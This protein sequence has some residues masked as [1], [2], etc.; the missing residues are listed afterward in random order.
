[1]WNTG[2]SSEYV[3]LFCMLCLLAYSFTSPQLSL[4]LPP[5]PQAWFY[6]VWLGLVPTVLSLV[7]M[8]VSVRELG[9]T[10]TAIIGALEPLTAVAIGVL[11]FSESLTLR[12]VLGI[13]IILFAVILVV[14]GKN[15]PFHIFHTT[16]TH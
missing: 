4:Q 5:S 14:V 9:A 6:A 15:H 10:P 7:L 12:L 3:L 2:S 8:T 16:T 1:M 13:I 11:V